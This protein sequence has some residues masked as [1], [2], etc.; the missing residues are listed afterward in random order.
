[1]NTASAW[2]GH[3]DWLTATYPRDL[4][5]LEQVQITRAVAAAA[6]KAGD[7]G[8]PQRSRWYGYEGLQRGTIF[9]GERDDGCCIRAS[10]YGAHV[11]ATTIP[12]VGFSVAR[13]DLAVTVWFEADDSLYARRAHEIAQAFRE[14]FPGPGRRKIRF[15]D[16]SGDGDTLYIGSRSSLAYGR[17]YDK[18][19]ES[20]DE[21][22]KHAW[23]FEVELKDEAADK[24]WLELALSSWNQ[25]R[26]RATVTNW[27]GARGVPLP[28]LYPDPAA[29]DLR[30][31]PAKSTVEAKLEWLRSQI[32]PSVRQLLK[33]GKEQDILTA[34]GCE[35][36]LAIAGSFEPDSRNLVDSPGTSNNQLT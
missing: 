36:R 21:Q 10:G 16:G 24:A 34:L 17:L 22:Y 19:R 4:S 25:N 7:D 32:G 15:I 35:G 14:T 9:T 5:L 11:L 18:A 3:V 29:V 20:G 31:A 23:R 26:I 8:H 27:F 13:L 28:F 12:D 6:T 33:L 30:L 1:M 2:V